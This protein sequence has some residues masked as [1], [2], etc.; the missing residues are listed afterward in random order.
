MSDEKQA[1]VNDPQ[2]TWA[3]I[4]AQAWADENFKARL[5]ADPAAVLSEAGL[6]VPAGVG[7]QVLE[8]TANVV[9]LVLPPP[10]SGGGVEES[11]ARVS[12]LSIAPPISCW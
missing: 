4:V 12:A 6:N 7:L 5:L 9:H 2:R 10:P 8:N 1:G 11:E 3:R